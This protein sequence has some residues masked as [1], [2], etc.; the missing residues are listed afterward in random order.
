MNLAG[1]LFHDK[2]YE[3]G[4]SVVY[5]GT[6]Q[7]DQKPVILKILKDEY[8]TPV[9]IARFRR[10]FETMHSLNADGILRAYALEKYN[11]SLAMVLEDFGGQSLATLLADRQLSLYEF[12]HLAIPMAHS[13]GAVHQHRLIH[14]DINPANV[15][16]NE[17]TDE[18]KII[19]FG[20]ATAVSRENPEVNSFNVMEGTLAYLSPE[21]TGRM[22]RTLDYRT[23]FYSLGVTFYEM[24]VGT[25][26]FQSRDALEL[27][28]AHLAKNPV[29]P[30]EVK[31]DIPQVISDIVMKLMAKTA[32]DRYQSAYGLQADLQRCLD[33]LDTTGHIAAFAI[34]QHDVSDRFQ[35]PQ[36]LYGRTSEIETLL[37]AFDRVSQGKT[38]MMLVSGYSGI[39][40]SALIQELHKP[41]VRQ[42][43]YFINGKF[44]QF[45][46]NIPY[47]AVIQAFRE[48][49]RQLLSESASQL[50]RWRE[51]LLAV[52]GANG[53]VIIEV[54]PEVELIV[55]VQPPVPQLPPAETQ[56]RFN[57][58]FQ[59]FVRVFASAEHPLVIFVDDLQWADSASL[60]L[61]EFFMTGARTS[62]ML[63]IGAYRDNEVTGA[64][65]LILTLAALQQAGA[66]VNQIGLSPLD[67]EDV[68]QFIADT[69]RCTLERA[70]PL[71]E[72][73][74]VKTN[75]NPFFM[76]EFLK[77]LYAE[78]LLI[79]DFDRGLWHW[80][81]AHIQAKDITDNV[82]ELM[83]G[84]VQQLEPETQQ[85]LK[86]AACIGHQFDLETLSVV[87][88]KS[89]RETATALWPA[90][91]TGL[92]L[93]R[94]EA[95]KLVGLD[96]QGLMGE[97]T[98][99][100]R[101]AHDRI[102]QAV[103]SLIPVSE[104]Q[105]VH[106]SVG[107]LL[108]RN[109]PP[110]ERD[111]KIFDIVNQLN[112]GRDNAVS[113]E[114]REALA[115]LNLLA[116]QKA[117]AATAYEPAL[118]YLMNGLELLDETSWQTNYAVMLALNMERSECE[119]LT[120]HFAEA[121]ETFNLILKNAQ[122]D[123]DRARVY[124]LKMILHMTKGQVK[125]AAMA[126]LAGLK[127]LGVEIELVPNPA[128]VNR[129]I[130]QVNAN[131][132]S[133]KIAELYDLP[134][135]TD[136]NQ[137]ARMS[138]LSDI[139]V[140]AWYTNLDLFSLTTSRM[141]N[142]SLQYGNSA[143]S[144]YGY[145]W[146]GVIAGSREGDYKSGYE[147]G[148]MALRLNEKVNNVRLSTRVYCIFGVFL[149]PWRDHIKY[150]LEINKKGYQAGL[151]VGDWAWAGINS[152]TLVYE[153]VIKGDPLDAVYQ[154]CQIYLDSAR[155]TKQAI[156]TNMV[157]VSQQFILS[158]KGL[159]HEPGSF[160]DDQYDEDKHIGGIRQSGAH[161]PLYW[162]Y[163]IKMQA[164]YTFRRYDEALQ[165]VL[166][167]DK[168]TKAG[169][170][171]GSI[172]RSQHFYYSSL[173][174]AALYPQMSAE[175][176]VHYHQML[177]DNQALLKIWAD[178]GPQNFQHKYLLVSA[179]IARLNGEHP[180][181]LF[182][183]AIMFAR[184]NEYT[185]DEALAC[186]LLAEWYLGKGQTQLGHYYLREA[187]YSYSRYGALAKV[188]D[189]D[190]RYPEIVPQTAGSRG[191]PR[192]STSTQSGSTIVGAGTIVQSMTNTLDLTSVI[193]SSQ[194]LSSEIVLEKLLGTLMKLVIENAGAQIGYLLLQKDGEWAIE[195]AGDVGRNEVALAAQNG[196]L[197]EQPFPKFI[198]NYVARTRE[199]VV[200]SNAAQI[201]QFTQ[202]PYVL[203]RRPRSVLCAPLIHKGELTGIIYL[204][205]NL[206]TGAFTPDRLTVLNMLSSQAAISIEN[207]QLY[208]QLEAYSKNLEQKVEQRTAELAHA[209][210][211][212]QEARAA[213]EAANASKSDFLA[214]VSHELRTPLTSILGFAKIIQKRLNERIFPLIQTDD[215]KT[216]QAISQVSS[217]IDIIVTEG[218]R[219]TTL[220]NNVLDLEKIEAGKMEWREE[221]LNVGEIV[222]Q[223]TAATN[224]LF[225]QKGLQ[226]VKD[227]PPDVML[228]AIGDRDK[229]IQVVINL[230]SNAV[231]FTTNGSVTC[232][233]RRRK[234][235]I[236]VRVIDTGMGIKPEDQ[237]KVFEKFKQVGD[238]LTD[239]PKGTGLG[240]P[241]CK[242][243][244]EHHGGRI[245][246]E[247]EIGKGSSFIFTLPV[248]DE[249]GDE[250][251]APHIDLKSLIHQLKAH[252]PAGERQKTILVADDE[253]HIR[254]LL[255]QQLV[256]E[257][258]AV[259]E[260]QNGP[261]TVAEVQR[262]K[263]DLVILD[264]MMPE[265]SGFDVAA[266][267]KNNPETMNV[268]IIILSIIEDKERGFRLG[269]DRY[270][271]KP[272]DTESLLSEIEGL[273][274]G[275]P[276][277]RNVLVID[278]DAATVQAL[279]DVLHANGYT[280]LEVLDSD[281]VIEKARAFKPDMMII[282]A[283]FS[284]QRNLMQSIRLEKELEN[285][286][287]MMYQ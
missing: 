237:P 61:I 75:G 97:I 127:L 164:L 123:A 82:V 187:R 95:Y 18:L 146:Y 222:N 43:G 57:Q 7:A 262:E 40:K 20:L 147:F 70:R 266:A 27:V 58:V 16:W 112:L 280:V 101:F 138:I 191:D 8:P 184:E 31:P 111:D 115:E 238:T 143:D 39:G 104:K 226:L 13:L 154:E 65:P 50:A 64:H 132:G 278:P 195:A 183:Q 34:G 267:L 114:D 260:T 24:L 253:A 186:E 286:F 55:G 139:L 242:E 26:P 229:L 163:K 124:K 170:S 246:V 5:R 33:E 54:I 131:L 156:P 106:W 236:E 168:A 52:L 80:E 53:Q 135:M 63:I 4:H 76:T 232:R 118:R 268:P 252:A 239:K 284:E 199:N 36:T 285:V 196:A 3:T 281:S 250:P 212:A 22:N 47:R 198:V 113:D 263:P 79:F 225:E 128:D 227:L 192:I 165:V 145:S 283:S 122:T 12:L 209:T 282:N 276:A 14:K 99:E 174:I 166:E 89:A 185:Q 244:I 68:N 240:L 49:M 245:W 152:Y 38:E 94:G 182:E 177:L 190:E 102:Q 41:L 25:L 15:V 42:R 241:I 91:V 78:N 144:A 203:T 110:D 45:Q 96:V 234:G 162:Y 180:V 129:E 181:T 173:I 259:R 228:D 261:E 86:L 208:T 230:I 150:G 287:I 72:L 249:S 176:Q 200:L 224:A 167:C 210:L 254:E 197:D 217:N 60:K 169:A 274:V 103:Y 136:P 220:I 235:E 100:Y 149:Q 44:D 189:L 188:A 172:E 219:L 194:A 258:Y 37:S 243:I 29:P 109:T 2:L 269:V 1:Y 30:S 275:G 277:K 207:A 130:E 48:L 88:M 121:E 231:K 67:L 119:Y 56:N 233:A 160:S 247:S 256:E 28:H 10:E 175:D 17:Q 120:G 87:F 273:F 211:E 116:G 140:P 126:G 19:D 73:V 251:N 83:A 108:Y 265:M 148:E 66:V 151:E 264:V 255:R 205:N 93:S 105:A 171:F 216:L 202:D 84:K 270:L 133:R 159:T 213:A 257:G 206:T 85:V 62:Y 71:A 32:E 204:E 272:I 193:K 161:R 134:E 98:A 125:D 201:G 6:R 157:I 107:Q 155:R 23:D 35:L 69:L 248:K 218:Q 81:L 21:Q 142:L 74:L 153:M 271:T 214:N 59:N 90:L 221:P 117:K 223:A 158:M 215:R 51:E 11:N 279:A 141:V 179:E 46:R 137:L 77:S 9:A 92:I 178:N